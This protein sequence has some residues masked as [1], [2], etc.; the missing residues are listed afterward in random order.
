MS[1]SRGITLSLKSSNISLAL[2]FAPGADF[3]PSMASPLALTSTTAREAPAGSSREVDTW[4]KRPSGESSASSASASTSEVLNRTSSPS[5]VRNAPFVLSASALSAASTA[6]LGAARAL[7]EC[8]TLLLWLLW[9]LCL[10]M[11]S[12]GHT[13]LQARSMRPVCLPTLMRSR[14]FSRGVAGGA[15]PA[16][17]AAVLTKWFSVARMALL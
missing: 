16:G 10:L 13:D 2:R 12:S 5:C 9:L 15:A 7:G 8:A 11:P 3:L 6:T 4:S 17:L 14:Y 1:T